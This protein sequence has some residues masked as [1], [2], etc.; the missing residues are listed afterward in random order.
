MSKLYDKDPP[1]QGRIVTRSL[2]LVAMSGS[3]LL[4]TRRRGLNSGA[5]FSACDGGNRIRQW[6]F[7]HTHAN[8]DREPHQFTERVSMELLQS[9]LLRPT[10]QSLIFSCGW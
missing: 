7:P 2:R 8:Y 3:A 6:L 4:P 5:A 9:L 10:E 1:A